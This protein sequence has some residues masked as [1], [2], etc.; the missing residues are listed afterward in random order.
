[1][2]SIPDGGILCLFDNMAKFPVMKGVR[3][4]CHLVQFV[5]YVITP[6]SFSANTIC[7]LNDREEGNEEVGV[8]GGGKDDANMRWWI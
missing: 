5:L 2:G 7:A 6:T 3:N 8:S 4:I 1:M